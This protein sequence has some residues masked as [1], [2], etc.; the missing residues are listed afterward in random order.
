MNLKR[1][2][3]NGRSSAHTHPLLH[4]MPLAAARRLDGA[5]AA[6]DLRAGTGRGRAGPW[7]WRH[8]RGA[9]E[10]TLIWSRAAQGR[11]PDIKELK[12]LVRDQV[13][14]GRNLGHIDR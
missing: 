5:R 10:H 4:T 8:L 12:Q 14:P 11:F 3:V 6:D 13:A 7:H 1:S 9:F 2:T